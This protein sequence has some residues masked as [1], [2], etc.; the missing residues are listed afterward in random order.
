MNT[1]FLDD[2]VTQLDFADSGVNLYE[3]LSSLRH[4]SEIQVS[5]YVYFVASSFMP[6]HLST[7]S[8]S[9]SDKNLDAPTLPLNDIAE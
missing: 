9:S 6:S 8:S 5:L 2:E 7:S 1:H 3:N 4:S